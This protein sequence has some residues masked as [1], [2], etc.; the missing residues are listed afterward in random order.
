MSGRFQHPE[1][2]NVWEK[3]KV[4]KKEKNKFNFE[5][6]EGGCPNCNMFLLLFA[7]FPKTYQYSYL[8]EEEEKIGIN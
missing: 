1:K 6:G 5:G 4:L 2:I 8:I 7:P 3:R